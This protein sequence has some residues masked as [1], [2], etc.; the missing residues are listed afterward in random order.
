MFLLGRLFNCASATKFSKT[1]FQIAW[2]L[3]INAG[4]WNVGGVDTPQYCEKNAN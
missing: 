2:R 1:D 4:I 3:E